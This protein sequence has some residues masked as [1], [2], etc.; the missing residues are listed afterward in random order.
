MTT[1]KVEQKPLTYQAKLNP[2]S[3]NRKTGPIPVSTTSANTCPDACPLKAKGC[4]AASGPIS[5]QWRK[6]KG[7]WQTFL[8]DVASLPAKTL[9]RHNQAGDLPGENDTLD[10]KALRQLISASLHTRGFTYTHK[11][12]RKASER[13]AIA[14]ANAQGFTINLSADNLAE[15]DRKAAWGIGPVAVILPEDVHTNTVTPQGRK[16]VICPFDTRGIQCKDCQLCSRA[17]RSCIVGFPAHGS[18]KKA[19]SAIAR[20]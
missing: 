16:V 5:W 11:P 7:D 4:Y 10:L 19:A 1:T 15:A 17:D 20:G 18:A 2:C 12:L 13:K 8:A 14:S 9:W 3:D 6:L